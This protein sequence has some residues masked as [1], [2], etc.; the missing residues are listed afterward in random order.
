MKLIQSATSLLAGLALCTAAQAQSKLI[1]KG[2]DTLGAKMVPQLAETYKAA[3]N[4]VNFEIAAEGSS[5]C[6]TALLD[7]TADF[8]MSSR[9]VKAKEKNQ[10][11]TKGQE[12]VE[13][14]AG[15]DMIAVIVNEAN[16]VKE[17][18]KEQIEG[19]FTGTITDWSEVGGKAGKINAYTRNTASGTYKTFQK[20]A[21]AKKDYGQNTQ[22]MAGNTQIAD[23]VAKDVNGIGYVGLAYVKRDGI[24]PA[25][26]NGV[27]P[28]PAKASEY[29]LS[30]NLYYYTV[31]QPTGETAKFIKWAT[32][33]EDAS[34]VITKVG[35][36]PAKK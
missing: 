12:L 4:N 28:T 27:L 30:R 9:A 1:I 32:T 5:Q 13:H 8:G 19:I 22:K 6:F 17:L 3:G 33:S 14:V 20:L 18:T 21:M 2:S 23:A 25:S 29:A 10:F 24:A 35:F 16:G 34:K 15:V 7:S 31:G 11:A 26:V 36:I